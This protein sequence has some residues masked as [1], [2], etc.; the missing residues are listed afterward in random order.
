MS[1]MPAPNFPPPQGYAGYAH[2]PAQR[3]NG[4]AI[5]SLVCGIVGCVPFVTS[6]AA[7]VLGI[8]SVRKAREPGFG[9]KS[10]A[11]VGLTL[12][13]VGVAGRSPGF[14]LTEPTRHC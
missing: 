12:G 7:L 1:Q 13:I 11:I 8:V 3:A 2:A 5:A 4:L 9:G 6:L 14:G 10:I